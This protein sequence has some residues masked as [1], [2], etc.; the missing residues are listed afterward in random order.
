VIEFRALIH[1]AT[2]KVISYEDWL[3]LLKNNNL[4]VWKDE[5]N[6]GTWQ[7]KP[8]NILFSDDFEIIYNSEIDLEAL[9]VIHE[10]LDKLINEYFYEDCDVYNLKDMVFNYMEAKESL[11]DKYGIDM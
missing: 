1:K 8:Q 4:L 11:K 9:K 3:E 7:Y 5:Y 2:E 6:N 10:S